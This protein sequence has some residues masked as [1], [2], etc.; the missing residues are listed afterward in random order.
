VNFNVSGK[1]ILQSGFSYSWSKSLANPTTSYA[2]NDNGQIKFKV[3]TVSGYGYLPI[4]PSVPT[5]VGDSVITGK[6]YTKLHYLTMPFI[7]SYKFRIRKFTVMAG[8][9]FTL[10]LLTSAILETKLQD[11]S[12]SQDEIEVKMYGLK[13]T[14][15]G[16][17]VKADL[18]YPIYRNW[19]LNLVASFKNTLTPINL[20]TII[21]TYPYNLGIGLGIS[22]SF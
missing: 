2:V 6:S 5:Q 3:N 19:S 21:S 8:M 18:Q 10:N 20:H 15:Y 12:Y 4:S 1:W 14:N 17:L 16:A 11:A 7:V 22:H 9:G 13:K